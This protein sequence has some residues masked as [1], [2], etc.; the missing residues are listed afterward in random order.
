MRT[1][2][3]HVQEKY[4]GRY[5]E[6]GKSPVSEMHDARCVYLLSRVGHVKSGSNPGGPPSKAK[7]YMRSIANQYREGMVK[8]TPEGE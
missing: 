4:L 5:A 8:R 2:D 1:L 3:A 6:E 7:K